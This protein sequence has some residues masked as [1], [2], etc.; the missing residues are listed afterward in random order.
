MAVFLAVVALL[1]GRDELAHKVECSID[2]EGVSNKVV[3]SISICNCENEGS[4]VVSGGPP[5]MY[6]EQLDQRQ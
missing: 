1:R 5:H 3:S 4:L 6:W 2:R